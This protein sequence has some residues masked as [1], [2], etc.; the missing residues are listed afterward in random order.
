MPAKDTTMTQGFSWR[1]TPFEIVEQ[2][3]SEFGENNALAG[4]W[5]TTIEK[6]TALKDAKTP[7]ELA[8]RAA[9]E[10]FITQA[11][12]TIPALITAEA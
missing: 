2:R 12:Q 9:I 1:L 7:D 4:M 5:A 8:E 10:A 3:A 6:M 11:I